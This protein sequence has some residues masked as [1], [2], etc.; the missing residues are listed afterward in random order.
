[1]SIDTFDTPDKAGQFNQWIFPDTCLALYSWRASESG[2]IVKVIIM[3]QYIHTWNT[4][5]LSDLV[6]EIIP[7][8]GDA[9]FEGE[10]FSC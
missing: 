10:H 1:M 5:S 9:R 8:G 3:E 6:I 7:G 4:L 2:S